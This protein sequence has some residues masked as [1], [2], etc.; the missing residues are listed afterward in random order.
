MRG[1]AAIMVMMR[2][3][4]GCDPTVYK[5]SYHLLNNS[6]IAVDFFF[7]VSGFVVSHAYGSKLLSGMSSARDYLARR[8]ARLFPLMSL[9]LVIG[10]PAFYLHSSADFENCS[11]RELLAATLSNLFFIPYLGAAV[12][13]AQQSHSLAALASGHVFPTDPP[14]WSI[15]FEVVASVA[16]IA[17]IR[18]SRRTLVNILLRCLGLL[19]L[20]S[21]IAAIKTQDF[22]FQLSVGIVTDNFLAGFPRVIYGFV[23]G[24]L[25]HQLRSSPATLSLVNRLQAAPK[26]PALILYAMFVATMLF[27][28]SAKGLY[29]LLFI[30]LLAPGLV[31]LGGNAQCEQKFMLFASTWLGWLSYPLYCLHMPIL[32]VLLFLKKTDQLHALHAMDA[33]V[34]AIGIALGSASASA[35]VV[36]RLQLQRKLTALLTGRLTWANAR[37]SSDADC[38]IIR[39]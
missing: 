6:Y 13:S 22:R 35:F 33:R 17:L 2:H 3:Y 25:L 37:Q 38:K 16:F 29:P 21:F 15:F 34:I 1:I 20:F 11:L 7:I 8:I 30:T 39:A 5:F 32:N 36:D 31:M 26:V 19:F 24:M 10:L 18:A 28:Y 9:G 12:I 23:C 14:L 4:Y 27:P